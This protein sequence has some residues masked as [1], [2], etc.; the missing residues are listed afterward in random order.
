MPWPPPTTNQ[1]VAKEKN[2]ILAT[3]ATD[4]EG[5]WQGSVK[6]DFVTK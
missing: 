6:R 4:F 1:R 2:G 5:L 3:C